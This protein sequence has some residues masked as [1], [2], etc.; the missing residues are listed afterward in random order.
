MYQKK[1]V[2]IQQKI[3]QRN[4]ALCSFSLLVKLD[5][6][7]VRFLVI[8]VDRKSRNSEYAFSLTVASQLEISYYKTLDY[9]FFWIAFIMLNK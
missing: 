6:I 2:D 9:A 7:L 4:T 8:M 3:N 5:D 1:G